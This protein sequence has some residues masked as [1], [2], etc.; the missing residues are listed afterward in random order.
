MFNLVHMTTCRILRMAN[1]F[2]NF[3]N[4][5]NKLVTKAT[6]Y[7]APLGQHVWDDICFVN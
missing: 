6:E 5:C 3:M 4:N 2:G 1:C 7:D